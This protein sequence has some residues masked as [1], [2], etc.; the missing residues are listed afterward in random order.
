MSGLGE[1]EVEL[2]PNSLLLDR[3]TS[4]QK[5]CA[6]FVA[7]GWTSKEI[8]SHLGISPSTV[9]NHIASAMGLLGIS[10]RSEL[11]KILDVNPDTPIW[12]DEFHDELSVIQLEVVGKEDFNEYIIEKK[13][14]REVVWSEKR[15]KKI[16]VYSFVFATALIFV[17]WALVLLTL[18]L[19]R[20]SA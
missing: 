18:R 20:A 11:R 7:K 19:L 4:R 6:H 14:G 2:E 16:Y 9:D 17:I 3:L 13:H 10:R 5:E 12:H 8:A 1:I 15:L